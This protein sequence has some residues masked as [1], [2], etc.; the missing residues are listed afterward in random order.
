MPQY[1]SHGK[2]K[3]LDLYYGDAQRDYGLHSRLKKAVR[4]KIQFVF[5]N[6]TAS[7]QRS[8]KLLWEEI[9][10][11]NGKNILL[12]ETIFTS[13]LLGLDENDKELQAKRF[14]CFKKETTKTPK[15]IENVALARIL[16]TKI[17]R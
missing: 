15:T 12:A 3:N 9:F 8:N 4:D 2:A 5:W 7:L 1:I 6:Y 13:N 17:I 14:Q 11:C 10:S 16:I